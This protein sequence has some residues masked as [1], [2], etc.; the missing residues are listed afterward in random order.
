MSQLLESYGFQGRSVIHPSACISQLASLG[1]NVQIMSGANIAPFSSIDDYSIINT[2]AN[3]DHDCV[4]GKAVHLAP[5]AA[6]AG[7]VIVDDYAFIGTNA[8]ILPRI[9]ISQSSTV[10][11]GSV[12]TKN[13]PES[14][15][16]IGSPA[17]LL[18][19]SN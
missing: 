11:A 18:S 4:I 3:V 2:G 7:E 6:L 10:G 14:V 17:R 13:V 19:N 8:T 5:N 15:T 1:K 12:V 16:V 9:H